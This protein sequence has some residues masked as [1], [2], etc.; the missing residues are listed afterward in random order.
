MIAPWYAIMY[1][2][3]DRIAWRYGY[4]LALHGSMSR[5]LDLVAIPWTEEAD[6]PEKLIAAFVRFVISKAD[7][8]VSQPKSAAM[9]HG[10]MSYIIPIGFGGGHYLDVSVMPRIDLPDAD[11]EGEK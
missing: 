5:D 6:D 1:E 8:H 3:L 4:A 11:K 7:V 9:P 2:K 10:R